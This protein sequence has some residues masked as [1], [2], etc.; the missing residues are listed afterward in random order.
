MVCSQ[1]VS[2][3][4]SIFSLYKGGFYVDK[5]LPKNSLEYS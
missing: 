4:F 1:A 2:S 5:D 3:A